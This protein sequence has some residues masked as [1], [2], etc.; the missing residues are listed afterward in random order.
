[1]FVIRTFNGEWYVYSD[2]DSKTLLLLYIQIRTIQVLPP[3]IRSRDQLRS[4]SDDHMKKGCRGLRAC[5][6]HGAT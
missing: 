5:P 2:Q 6:Q 4:L 3:W 1:M